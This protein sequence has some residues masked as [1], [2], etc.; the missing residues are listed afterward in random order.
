MQN[1]YNL[2]IDQIDAFIRKYYKN[3]LIRGFILFTLFFILALLLT[4]SLEFFGKFPIFVRGVLFF[5]FIVLQSYL[6]IRLI[7]IPLGRLLAIG[8]RISHLQA[9]EII[10]V[11]FPEVADKLKNTIQLQQDLVQNLGNIAL[12]S[13]SIQQRATQLS[14]ISFETAIQYK[15]QRQYLKYL[16]PVLFGFLGVALF[17]PQILTQGSTRVLQYTREFKEPNPYIFTFSKIPSGMEEGASFELLVKVK[18]APG[19]H[20]LPKQLYIIHDQGKFLLK[21]K[22]RDVF[23]YRFN[24]LQKTSSF[25]VTTNEFNSAK[26]WIRINKKALIGTIKAHC[27]FPKYL[28]R[29]DYTYENTVDLNIPEGTV[30]RWELATKNVSKLK[31][32][33]QQ[34]LRYLDPVYSTFDQE[35][36]NSLKQYFIFTNAQTGKKI[37]LLLQ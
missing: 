22:K 1:P 35:Y 21:S 3:Q 30:V 32:L 11:F 18:P 7:A 9:A 31:I 29:S 26:Q 13:A 33:L 25:I 24:Q 27:T 23:S 16:V 36:R 8:N 2:L 12:I 15:S 34:K 28:N 14:I 19:F 20:T 10:G 5:G 6:F 17:I 4:S 37:H